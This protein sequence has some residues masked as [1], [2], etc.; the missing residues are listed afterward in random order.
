MYSKYY[1]V[2]YLKHFVDSSLQYRCVFGPFHAYGRPGLMI[3]LS[4]R[5]RPTVYVQ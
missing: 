3:S 1:V 5:L 4:F 2:I